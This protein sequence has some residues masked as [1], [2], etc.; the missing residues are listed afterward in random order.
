MSSTTA[1]TYP[2]GVG[3]CCPPTPPPH[4][5]PAAALRGAPVRRQRDFADADAGGDLD[6]YDDFIIREVDDIDQGYNEAKRRA[7]PC[8][9]GRGDCAVQRDNKRG[10]WMYVCSSQPKCKHVAMCEEV[11]QNPQSPPAVRSDPKPSNPCV[12]SI[13]RTP[14]DDARTRI[15]NVNP[16]G[17]GATTPVNVS[18][19]A[20]VARTPF[21]DTKGVGATTPVHVSPQGAGATT[22]VN[23]SPQAA[24]A[25]T[26][27]KYTSKGV[28]A[29]T[30]IH[31]SPQGAG[32]TTPVNVS[33]QAAVAT[34]PFN[35]SSKGVGTT[36]PVHVSPQGAGAMTPVHVSPQGAGTTAAVKASPRWHRSNDGQL[37][38]QCTAGKCKRLRVGNEDCYVCPIPKGQGA[39]SF[40][41]PVTDVVKGP[42]QVGDYNTMEAHGNTA[43]G[44]G[45]NNGN[46]SANPAQ[47]NDD[48]WPIPFD[49]INNEIVLTGQATPRAVVHQNSPGTPRQP[50]AMA[51]TPATSPM[52]PFGSRSPM[53]GRPCYGC[54]EEG[55]WISACPKRSSQ[56]TC[57]RCGMVGHRQANCP[58]PR[59]S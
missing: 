4:P 46:E 55:H 14:V 37:I 7:P 15:N 54:G 34:T 35:Y 3:S 49:V 26:P 48:E 21:N 10:R 2:E 51:K 57:F 56:N 17:A 33:P 28:G 1:D 45:D 47:P 23:V 18:P 6:D 31:V 9:C 25:T 29:M 22:P 58:Q 16:H 36:T 19:Q 8:V 39:C 27:F 41:V 44:V 20:A 24:V 52:T 13:P 42:P 53:T 43:V 12:F 32:A 30:P 40:K 59:G 11:D 38:C 5:K 50:T